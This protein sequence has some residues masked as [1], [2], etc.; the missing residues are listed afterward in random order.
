MPRPSKSHEVLLF[1]KNNPTEWT[2][3]EVASRI[4]VSYLTARKHLIALA[5]QGTITVS[6]AS[7]VNKPGRKE[8]TYMYVY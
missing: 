1:L 4:G 3:K 5:D 7:G 8:L 2:I 6:T